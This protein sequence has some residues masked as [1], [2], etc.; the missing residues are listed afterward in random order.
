MKSSKALRYAKRLISFEST[1]HLSNRKI[2][3]YLEIKLAKHGFVVEKVEYRDKRNVR[4]VNIVAKKGRGQGGLAYFG[5]SDVVPAKSWFSKR[6]GP[7]EATIAR[8]RLY[9]RGACDMK[10]SLACM[11]TASQLFSWEDLAQP[12]YF[13]CTA[14]EEVGFHGARCVAEE[15]KFFRE[16]VEG[17]TKGIIGEPTSL[18]IVHA[19]KGSYYLR[20]VARGKA[21]HSGTEQ[22]IN[23]NL[24]MIPFLQEMKAIHDETETNSNLKNDLFDPPTLRWNIG[25][26][27]RTKAFN[28]TAPRSVCT[29]YFRPMPG[30]DVEPLISRAQ[31][32]AK[33]HDIELQIERWGEPL[34]VDPD[35]EFVTQSLQLVHRRKPK[36]VSYGTDGGA[37]GELENL[38]IFGPGNIEQAHTND[39]WISL[40]QISLGTEMY[41][42]M[43]EHWCGSKP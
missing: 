21:A 1:S 33:K 12:L 31:M 28:I 10:G 23:A 16:M 25:V 2:S 40:E 19:H 13:V 32:A 41:R 27:D 17:G 8:E 7:T 38:F 36:T 39:E 15:S 24:A 20:G 42:K 5:H 43:I 34:Y 14:D 29:V 18:E 11:L 26:N 35:S 4:K 9:G 37:F 6:F 3:K 22:G 30:V